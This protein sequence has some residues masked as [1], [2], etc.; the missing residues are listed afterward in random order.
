MLVVVLPS[1]AALCLPAV[2][3]RNRGGSWLTSATAREVRSG[4]MGAGLSVGFLCVCVLGDGGLPKMTRCKEEKKK[5]E[6]KGKKRKEGRR[7]T[8][9]TRRPTSVVFTRR[10]KKT[11]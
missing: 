6:K 2:F 8:R 5:H 10:K 4:W 1:F 9:G 11:R 3:K 7:V